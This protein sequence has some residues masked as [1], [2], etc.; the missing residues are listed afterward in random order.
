MWRGRYEVR[1]AGTTSKMEAHTRPMRSARNS[2]LSCPSTFSA[3][4][5][6]LVVLVST[7]VMV[8]TIWSV[9]WLLFFYSR[10][11]HAQPFVKIGRGTCPRALWSI[12]R[13][14]W[15]Y[16]DIMDS[17]FPFSVSKRNILI[18]GAAECGLNIWFLLTRVC[19]EISSYFTLHTH[20]DIGLMPLLLY[21]Y[22]NLY[23]L[24]STLVP[25][26]GI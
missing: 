18:N 6:S 9:S 1:G 5:V 25:A 26:Q 8:S 3:L 17:I 10:C 20:S 22:F 16:A 15:R 14:H 19:F 13:R 11:P 12:Y 4:Q 2:F 23:I 21:Y 24:K 7:F